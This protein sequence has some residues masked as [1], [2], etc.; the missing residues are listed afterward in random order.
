MRD[1]VALG[2]GT[3][4]VII[5]VLDL[6][7]Q[8]QRRVRQC[9]LKTLFRKPMS[10]VCIQ[11]RLKVPEQLGSQCIRA[12]REIQSTLQR[13]MLGVNPM[14]QCI[15]NYQIWTTCIHSV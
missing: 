11:T 1:I 8:G 3:Q 5:H 2:E 10:N 7:A 14:S 15:V 12:A 4:T 9:Q 13:V 6:T